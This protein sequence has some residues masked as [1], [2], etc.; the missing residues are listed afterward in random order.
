MTQKAQEAILLSSTDKS[1]LLASPVSYTFRTDPAHALG[2]CLL[3][4]Y[5]FSQ[6][7]H[8][9]PGSL[10]HTPNY[11]PFLSRVLLKIHLTQARATQQNYKRELLVPLL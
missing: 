5:Y 10:L 7:H 3:T 1:N 6:N 4:P 2:F 11:S 9:L 8:L